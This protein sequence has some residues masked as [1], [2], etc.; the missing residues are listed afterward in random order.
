VGHDLFQWIA[1]FVESYLHNAYYGAEFVFGT[2]AMNAN[3]FALNVLPAVIFFASTVQM[4]YYLGTIQWVLEKMAVVFISL[5]GIS[6]AESIVAVA[7][8]S[9][10]PYYISFVFLVLN[11]CI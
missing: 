9:T 2:A 11:M 8:V 10:L 4:L 5:M 7:S 3:T 1:N 6:G